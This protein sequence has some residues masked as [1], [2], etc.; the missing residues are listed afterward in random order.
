MCPRRLTSSPADGPTF[1]ALIIQETRRVV[2]K[3]RKTRGS[4]FIAPLSTPFIAEHSG[5]LPSTAGDVIAVGFGV[6]VS[7]SVAGFHDFR[8][9]VIMTE[10]VLAVLRFGN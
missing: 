2:V 7:V 6:I 3:Q 1:F 4:F 5:L 8:E 10:T 9:S